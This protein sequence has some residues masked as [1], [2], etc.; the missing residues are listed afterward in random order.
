MYNKLGGEV[1][2]NQIVDDF[3]QIM[4]TDPLAKECFQTHSG[5]DM[6]ETAK[7]LKYFLS[8]WLG[9]PPLYMQTYGH[10]RLRM[11]HFPFSIGELESK[12][13]LYCMRKSLEK[14]NVQANDQAKLM[15][16]FENVTKMIKNRSED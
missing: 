5:K 15:E 2:I 3:Y 9:G 8:G 6:A 12:Q 14:N 10:P 1:V 16:A 13:W 4:S 7:K 11:R